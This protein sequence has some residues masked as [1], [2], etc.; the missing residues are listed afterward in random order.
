MEVL[1]PPPQPCS[2]LHRGGK[3]RKRSP[4]PR[5]ASALAD[6]RRPKAKVSLNHNKT[7]SLHRFP[8]RL[9]RKTRKVL[10]DALKSPAQNYEEETPQEE[11]DAQFGE[12]LPRLGVF[13]RSKTRSKVDLHVTVLQRDDDHGWERPEL[14]GRTSP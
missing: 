7:F 6:Q 14:A 3:S 13:G 9:C 10:R 2:L 4:F 8:S 1:R 5:L 12:L 11:M